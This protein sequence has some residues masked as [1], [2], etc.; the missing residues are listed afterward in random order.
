MG[1]WPTYCNWSASSS[2][3]KLGPET[4]VSCADCL[5]ACQ[6]DEWHELSFIE[7]LGVTEA[8]EGTLLDPPGSTCALVK[9]M[10]KRRR[11]A[12]QALR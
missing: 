7:A 2:R 5:A 12:D 8:L 9:S 10:R 1:S 4:W 11:F 3:G 6:A